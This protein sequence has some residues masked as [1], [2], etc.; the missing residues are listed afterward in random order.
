MDIRALE[1]STVLSITVDQAHRFFEMVVRL[2][3]GTKNKLM[4]WNADGTEL[5]IK[6]GALYVQSCS[7]LGELEGI[8]VVDNGLLLE[9][10][11]GDITIQAT[12]FSIEKLV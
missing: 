4:A 2:D 12:S 9:G 3:D 5:A 11:F 10:D 1:E 6:L 7:E 8:N